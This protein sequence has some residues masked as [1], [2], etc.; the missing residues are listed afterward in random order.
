MKSDAKPREGHRPVDLPQIRHRWVTN[1]EVAK[2]AKDL[3]RG[4]VRIS[5]LRFKQQPVPDINPEKW[6]RRKLP[7]LGAAA[8][9]VIVITY[10]VV[11]TYT[12]V[13]NTVAE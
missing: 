13:L 7:K 3:S 6:M 2:P 5:S 4:P 9:A 11:V 10:V 8:I 12:G 1:D